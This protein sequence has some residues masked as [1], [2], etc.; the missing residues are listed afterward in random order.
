[1]VNEKLKER[2]CF[3]KTEISLS[4]PIYLPKAECSF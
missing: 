2:I 4:F 3:F 1:M